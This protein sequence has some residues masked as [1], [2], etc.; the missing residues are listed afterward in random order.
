LLQLQVISGLQW[1]P[2]EED[3]QQQKTTTKKAQFLKHKCSKTPSKSITVR[4]DAKPSS[5]LLLRK[6]QHQLLVEKKK[7]KKKKKMMLMM[8]LYEGAIAIPQLQ[9]LEDPQTLKPDVIFLFAEMH[10]GF[11]FSS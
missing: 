8:M 11:C 9:N 7:K 3:H 10:E 6:K 1:I 2:E 5:L 4:G